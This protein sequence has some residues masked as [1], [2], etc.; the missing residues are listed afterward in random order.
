MDTRLVQ[1]LK[2]W[3]PWWQ[4]GPQGIARFGV[5]EYKRELFDPIR[6]IYYRR[7]QAVSI[8]G[9]RQ[10]GKTTI[11][12][13]CIKELL[14]RGVPPV[15]IFF[16][17][18]EDSYLSTQYPLEMLFER[19]VEEYAESVL[20]EDIATTRQEL[21]FFFDEVHRLPNWAKSIKSYYDRHTPIAFMVSGSASFG[22]QKGKGES[23]LGRMTEFT[24]YPFSFRESV[25]FWE[26]ESGKTSEELLRLKGI[27]SACHIE[28]EKYFR[29]SNLQ[30]LH[31][32]LLPVFQEAVVWHK[33]V[34]QQSLRRYLLQGG[35]PRVWQQSDE[36]SQ[37][38]HLIEQH[39]Q[40][41]IREDLPQIAQ[42]RKT[43]ELEALYISLLDRL[44]EEIVLNSLGKDINLSAFTLM[45]YL[46]YLQKTFLLF[47]V[48]RTKTK[49]VLHQRRASRVRF[50]ATD[51]AVRVAVRKSRDDLFD[52]TNEMGLYA[53]NLVGSALW[54]RLSSRAG[55]SLHY[56]RE[57]NRYEV[58]FIV[59]EGDSL[60]PVEVKWR[61]Q[62]PALKSLDR[63]CKKWSLTESVIVT[64]DH[65]FVYRDGRLS[66][67]LWFFLLVV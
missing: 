65:E 59:K 45:K 9:M 12:H 44:G 22:M 63:L 49:N 38:R 13:Q 10:V 39:L 55:N 2:G 18:F 34:F 56:Y 43:S 40:K 14:E 19:V 33:T 17:S 21:Y 32:S 42:V 54:R 52:D 31:S 28:G 24:L 41:V 7:Q 37:H 23:L 36:Y 8:V 6:D 15:H 20:K 48:E 1:Q 50:Y 58:D 11:M 46:D 26:S 62:I 53:E 61:E 3:N 67:P 30:R 57:G 16:I 25:D 51:S 60:L 35:F 29:Q 47:A 4:E 5:P 64:R 27:L 66:L